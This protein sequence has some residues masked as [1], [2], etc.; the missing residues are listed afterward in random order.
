MDPILSFSPLARIHRLS[1]RWKTSSVA[2]AV[3]FQSARADSPPLNRKEAFPWYGVKSFSPLVRI[4]RLSTGGGHHGRFEEPGFS[5]LARIHRLSTTAMRLCRLA[6]SRF[7]PLARI[8]RLSTQ[9]PTQPPLGLPPVSVRSRGFTASQREPAVAVGR[10]GSIVSVRS[11][12]FTASQ[13]G[14]LVLNNQVVALFQSARADSPPLNL[15]S[16]VCSPSG[17]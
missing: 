2:S 1:T 6:W 5:P 4:H 9:Q 10:G 17:E 3:M 14:H 12:G 7:S 15:T 8:H 13:L 11:R 16:S